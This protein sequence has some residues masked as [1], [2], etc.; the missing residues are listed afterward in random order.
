MSLAEAQRLL[1][2]A[3]LSGT[4]LS[5]GNSPVRLPDLSFVLARTPVTVAAEN[6]AGPQAVEGLPVAVQV[7]SQ[8]ALREG[9]EC[10][11]VAYLA[12]EPPVREGDTLLLVLQV[13]LLPAD[14]GRHPLGLSGLQVRLREAGGRWRAEGDPVLFAT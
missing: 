2:G 11:D 8:A 1:L 9:D 3:V 5:G 12:F 6:L 14:P 7:R 13:R 10:S 4:G